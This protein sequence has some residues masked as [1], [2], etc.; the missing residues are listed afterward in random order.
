MLFEY[1]LS[2]GRKE[3]YQLLTQ[4]LLFLLVSDH[5]VDVH[6]SHLLIPAVAVCAV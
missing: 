2:Q 3:K 6:I 1:S 5:I 4:F